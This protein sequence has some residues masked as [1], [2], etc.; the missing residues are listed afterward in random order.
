MDDL[1]FTI[2]KL[3]SGE[4]FFFAGSGISYASNLPSAYVILKHTVNAFLP[5]SIPMKEKENICSR[6]QPEVFYESVIG[7][8]QTYES[9]HIWQSLHKGMQ[10]RHHIRC[11]PSLS[12]LFIA[13]YSI[14]NHLPII[15]TNFDSMF[16]QACELLGI[17]YKLLLPTDD[18]Y[19]IDSNSLC[20]C[21]IH[22]S[23]QDNQDMY[24][25][26]SLWT[27]MTQITT[28]NTKWI[29]YICNVMNN[30]HLCFVGYSGRDIDLFPYLSEAPN[31]IGAKRIV[32]V[33]RFDGDHSD[34]ASKA[35]NAIRVHK[36]PSELFESS[37]DLVDVSKHPKKY[38][39]SNQDSNLK[40]LLDH[41][42]NE[43]VKMDLLS[44]PE[45]ELLYCV[46]LAKIGNY[47]KAHK[48]AIDIE[49]N[50]LSN[51]T[52]HLNKYLLLLTC[53]RLSHE[54]SRYESC[55]AYAFKVLQILS[56]RSKYDVNVELQARCLLSEALRMG[57]PNDIYFIQPKR[58]GDYMYVFYVAGYF[59]YVAVINNIKMRLHGLKYIELRPETQH[60]LIEHR[61]RYYAL[62]QSAIGSPQRGWNRYA[63][64][65]LIRRWD[66][67]K[68][69]SHRVGYSAGI[70]N[71][72]KFKYRLI[73]SEKTRNESANI[74]NLTTSA[75]GSELIVR[76]EADQ[77]LRDKEFD[78]CRIKFIEYSDMAKKSGN[79]LN[80]IKGFIGYAYSNYMEGNLPLL[81]EPLK[82]RYNRLVN[83]VE[84]RR[85][86]EHFMY[87]DRAVLNSTRNT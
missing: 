13:E 78:K 21:K 37:L 3:R 17:N 72:G 55:R 60:E 84:A 87:I 30:K 19:T 81:P 7:M 76:N 8:T 82:N 38:T 52:R 80:E 33:N 23:I 58:L 12:H 71:A 53:A 54:I 64:Q 9:L 34:N 32:W 36:W 75:T 22:G 20:I 70:A 49:K 61:I 66:D 5:A 67:I 24:S 44:D 26:Q 83:L 43:L 18:P 57:I 79:V 1:E 28:V 74:Y 42:E 2:D 31:K 51:L 85:W 10:N 35:C 56:D 25:P 47:R 14:N 73:P 86:K 6:I 27:T 39:A 65:F 41:L 48:Y 4:I 63:K 46:L 11:E 62:I 40:K 16:E 69:M 59:N 68:E 50:K 15:T 77:L 45:K 29:E